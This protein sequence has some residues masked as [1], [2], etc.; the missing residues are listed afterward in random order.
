[1]IESGQTCGKAKYCFGE[2]EGVR[3]KR[4]NQIE[5]KVEVRVCVWVWWCVVGGL[6][7]FKSKIKVNF[8][9]IEKR[10]REFVPFEIVSLI[11]SFCVCENQMPSCRDSVC[12]WKT[13][14][15][16]FEKLF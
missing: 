16:A 7:A 9:P 14:W 12:D 2:R 1:M 15:Q 5:A 3:A 10:E 4:K 6:G 13:H 8:I 11:N